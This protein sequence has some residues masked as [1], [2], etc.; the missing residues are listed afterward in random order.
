MLQR[1]GR[2]ENLEWIATGGQGTVYRAQDTT[3]DRIVAVK[4]INQPVSADPEYLYALQREA[5]LA[6]G[7]DHANI[8]TVYDFQVEDGIA[9]IVMEY[10]PDALDRHIRGGR[11]LPWR[12]AIEI[13]QQTARA[14][15]HAHDRGVVHRDIKPQNILLREDG[16]VA[17]SDFG[18]ARA[19]ASST[20]TV[21]GRVM[22]M[23]AYMA[24]EQWAS[25]SLDGRSNQYA[26]G[27]VLYEMLVGTS[28]FQG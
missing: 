23:P 28:P 2:Y 24:P 14:M 25:A 6:A 17:V 27:V 7:L 1:I 15:Q 21:S 22:G 4:V 10:V 5:R 26:L 20:S 16:T 19:L 12:R 8:T 18:I 9:F 11:R 3:L 13:A